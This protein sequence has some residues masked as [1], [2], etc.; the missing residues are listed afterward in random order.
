MNVVNSMSVWYHDVDVIIWVDECLIYHDDVFDD[1]V[2]EYLYHD[3]MTLMLDK[4]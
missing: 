4:Q 2:F 1:D 3:R